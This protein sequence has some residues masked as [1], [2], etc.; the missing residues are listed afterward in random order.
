[1]SV[2]HPTPI[3]YRITSPSPQ[4]G[5]NYRHKFPNISAI[6]TLYVHPHTNHANHVAQGRGSVQIPRKVA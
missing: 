5:K 2:Y 1:M 4:T 3:H 6:C